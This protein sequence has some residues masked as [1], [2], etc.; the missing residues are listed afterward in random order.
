MKVFCALCGK[1]MGE[2]EGRLR[3]GWVIL[4]EG[5]HEPPE[6]FAGD[7]HAIR[8]D[9]AVEFLKSAFGMKK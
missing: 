6:P 8:D 9:D 7:V 4:C 2:L 1:D 3:K 5:C